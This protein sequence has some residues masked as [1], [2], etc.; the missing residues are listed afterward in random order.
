M[1]V[2]S[3]RKQSFANEGSDRLSSASSGRWA[4]SSKRSHFMHSGL[5]KY[6]FDEGGLCLGIS[7]PVSPILLRQLELQSEIVGRCFWMLT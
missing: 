1:N 3:H 6:G 2:C 5:F 4:G 7:S